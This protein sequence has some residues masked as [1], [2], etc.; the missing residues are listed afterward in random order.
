M[1]IKP[2]PGSD[3]TVTKSTSSSSGADEKMVLRPGDGARNSATFQCGMVCRFFSCLQSLSTEGRYDD[4]C[5][6]G[7]GP[8]ALLPVALR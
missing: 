8:C 2:S 4:A 6:S 5:A 3:A 1:I 7:C